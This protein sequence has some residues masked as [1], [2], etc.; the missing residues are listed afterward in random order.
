LHEESLLI[1]FKPVQEKEVILNLWPKVFPE[2]WPNSYILTSIFPCFIK[3]I[4][5]LRQNI[6]VDFPIA[7]P[8]H[9]AKERDSMPMIEGERVVSQRSCADATQALGG[10]RSSDS[11][12][13][14]SNT[15]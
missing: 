2:S 4:W 6:F 8:L 10:S 14:D 11:M 15:E 1:T 3:D 13:S 9:P 12:A 5:V 7:L